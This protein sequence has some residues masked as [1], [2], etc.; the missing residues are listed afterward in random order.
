METGIG[1]TPGRF[2]SYRTK[3]ISGGTRGIQQFVSIAI[4]KGNTWD[5]G[6]S[7]RLPETK[8]MHQRYGRPNENDN[9]VGRAIISSVTIPR[10]IIAG[11]HSGCGKTSIAGGIMQALTAR[12]YCVQPFKVGP[13]FIDPSHHSAICSRPSRNLDP[14]M[15]GEEGVIR[16]F[17]RASRGADIAVIEGVMGMHDGLEGSELCSTAQVAKLLQAPL[18]LVVDVGGMSR[19][20]HALIRGYRDYDRQISFAG[21]IF[22]R[23]GSSRHRTM[24]EQGLETVALGWIP[25]RKTMEVQSR[26]LGLYMAH[27]TQ[28]IANFGYFIEEDCNIDLLLQCAA[29]APILTPPQPVDVGR[30][31]SPRIGVAYDEAFCFYYQD[32]LDLMRAMGAHLDFFS[33]ISDPLPDVDGVYLGGGYPELYAKQLAS[34]RCREEIGRA[35]DSG[36]PVYAECGGLVY[37]TESISCGSDWR[38]VGALPAYAIQEDR[39]QALGYVDAVSTGATEMMTAGTGMKGH[40]FHYSRVECAPDARFAFRLRR[41]KGIRNGNDGLFVHNTLAGYT[42]AYFSPGFLTP[43]MKRMNDWRKQ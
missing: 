20:V 21:V 43:L 8:N 18:I 10:I 19:S 42:H 32:N 2:E 35:I 39:F 30:E 4:Q 9:L 3:V 16:T 22:N 23:V 31:G 26:H 13:D 33:P 5:D 11:T 36:L 1:I 15:M 25:F 37:L 40:E 38:M 27:E 6:D 29:D 28:E 34:S 17:L 41:G 7:L 14:F 24:I 12:G